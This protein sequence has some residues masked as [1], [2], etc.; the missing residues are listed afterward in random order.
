[1]VD[2]D[3]EVAEDSLNRMVSC[4][5]HDTRIMGICGETQ[6]YNEQDTWVTMIQVYEYY[7]SHHLAKAFESL[8]GT[9]TCLPGCFCMYRIKTPVKQTP[10]IANTQILE[11]YSDNNV[12]TLHKK[13]LLSL[14]ED[15]FLTTLM[16][17]HFPKMRT[18]FTPD[19]MCK[20]V[21][22]DQWDVLLSQRRR[23]INSTIHNLFELLYL[24]QLCGFCVCSMRFV[25]FLDLFATL[26][27]PATV[28]YLIYLIIASIESQTAPTISLILLGAVY[29]MQV[30]IF[31]LKRQFQHIGWMVIY[32]L[33]MPVFNFYI[34]LYAF[35][36]FDDFS[37][38]NTRVVLG[39]NGQMVQVAKE[40]GEAFD[41]DSIPTKH[42]E[43]AEAEGY[44]NKDEEG[45]D[46]YDGEIS[47]SQHIWPEDVGGVPFNEHLPRAASSRSISSMQSYGPGVGSMRRSSSALLSIVPSSSDVS[48]NIQ[49]ADGQEMPS[50]SDLV[51]HIR[52]AL[53]TADLTTVTKKQIRE[54]L[55]G[56]F[57][58][59]LT[60]KRDFINQ[61]IGSILDGDM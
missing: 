2:A 32:I 37:W 40:E 26:V 24:N 46:N 9:V 49:D 48:I 54:Q 30:V 10:L 45:I 43:E 8:F 41:P 57:G 23:W 42:W 59:D 3:T 20:T 28:L 4:C 15:R 50:D 60:V 34:P 58:V 39:D 47:N 55:S 38:G 13:N 11:E 31:V 35:W 1:M 6:I 19:A 25:V 17:K 29:G 22:P 5:I 14:G 16:L 44:G 33:A 61:V 52:H 18:K 53:A 21:A 51:R 36:H 7:I 56:H 27:M 12:E